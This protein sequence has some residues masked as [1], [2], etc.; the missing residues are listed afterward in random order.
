VRTIGNVIASPRVRL[1]ALVGLVALSRL[2]LLGQGYGSDEDSW[3]NAMAALRMRELGHYAISRPPGFPMFESAMAVLAPFGWWATNG[4]AALAGV[5][6]VVLLR[7]IA[8]RLGVQAPGWLALAFAFCG[9]LWVT[10]SQTMDYAWGLAFMLAAYLALLDRRHLLGGILLALATGCRVTMGPQVLGAAALLALGRAPVR[11][12]AGLALGFTLTLVLLFLPVLSS[13]ELGDLR[14][15]AVHHTSQAR[16]TPRTVVPVLRAAGA[17]LLGR[18]GLL[19]LGLAVMVTVLERTFAPRSL[20]W[21]MS[22]AVVSGA[23]A[24]ESIAVAVC[25]VLFALIPYENAYL[26][27]ALPFVLL[28]AARLLR[29]RWIIAMACVFATESLVTMRFDTRQVVPGVLFQER[30]TRQADMAE[31]RALLRLEPASPTVYLTDRVGLLRLRLLDRALERTGP[32]WEEIRH[33]GVALWRRDRRVGYA[34]GL[35]GAQRGSLVRAGYRVLEAPAGVD[36]G[37]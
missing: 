34:G 26:L 8:A 33:P 12:W 37:H 5:V 24:Y 3:R 13:P 11:A 30:A 35:T 25:V 16:L 20:P 14:A 27:P 21:R 29:R 28:L 23:V 32:Q 31:T 9:S 1:A 18:F 15:Q 6:A 36:S 19:L 22:G 7:R 2:P 4:A 17:Y 10:T